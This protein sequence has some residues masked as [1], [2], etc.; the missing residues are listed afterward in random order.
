MI[1]SH[2]KQIKEYLWVVSKKVVKTGKIIETSTNFVQSFV[3]PDFFS[4]FLGIV[5]Q[6]LK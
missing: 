5:H 4:E 6:H 3:K 2:I 1:L